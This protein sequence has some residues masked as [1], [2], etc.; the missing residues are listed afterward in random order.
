MVQHNTSRRNLLFKAG[1]LALSPVITRA[2]VLTPPLKRYGRGQTPFFN[3]VDESPF[4][5]IRQFGV[6]ESMTVRRGF[7]T[8]NNNYF[9]KLYDIPLKLQT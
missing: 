4:M 3:H 1:A 8:I 5:P 7:P 9:I 2:N 6:I